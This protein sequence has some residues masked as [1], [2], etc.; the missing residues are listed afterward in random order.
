M[1]ILQ[2]AFNGALPTNP[3]LPHHYP[4]NCVVYTGTHDN[5]TIRG[6]YATASEAERAFAMRYLSSDQ[7]NL[8]AAMIRAAWASVAS[9]SLAS[10]QDLLNLDGS[11][12][13]NF[14]GRESG[15]WGWRMRED[16]LSDRLRDWLIELN[17]LYSRTRSK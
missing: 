3:F 9:M 15:N 13:M 14:P 10:M 7:N 11:A 16:A 17:T 8:S 6:W 5:D 1:K 12:R 4:S 2:F